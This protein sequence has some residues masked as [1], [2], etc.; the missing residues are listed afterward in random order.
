MS[1]QIAMKNLRGT[2]PLSAIWQPVR[3][4]LEPKKAARKSTNARWVCP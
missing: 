2:A 3:M 4:G 1:V